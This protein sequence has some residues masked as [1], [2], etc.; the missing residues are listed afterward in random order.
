[1]IQ[2]QLKPVYS[3]MDDI[4]K[5]PPKEKKKWRPCLGRSNICLGKVFGT[6]ENQVCHKCKWFYRQEQYQGTMTSHPDVSKFNRSNP[7]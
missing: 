7:Y 6:V 5:D 2:R 3:F 4:P 1:M